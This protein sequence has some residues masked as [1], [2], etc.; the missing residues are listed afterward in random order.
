MLIRLR[1]EYDASLALADGRLFHVPKFFVFQPQSEDVAGDVHVAPP[2]HP[3]SVLNSARVQIAGVCSYAI[4][5]ECSLVVITQARW[6]VRAQQ[7]HFA[8]VWVAFWS[9]IRH[10]LHH[11]GASLTQFW[12]QGIDFNFLLRWYNLYTKAQKGY[13]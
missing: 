1:D 11:C 3:N 4:V 5:W 7:C 9:T 2:R 10:R 6:L 8:L 13:D 12:S